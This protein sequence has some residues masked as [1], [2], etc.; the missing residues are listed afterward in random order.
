MIQRPFFFRA[1]TTFALF[2]FFV[3]LSALSLVAQDVRINEFLA[4]NQNGLTDEDGTYSDWIELFNASSA[5]VDLEGWSLTDDAIRLDKW[6]FPDVTVPSGGYL[7][8]FASGNDRTDPGNPLH[9]N[10]KLSGSGEYLALVDAGGRIVTEFSPFYPE[11]TVDQSWGYLN[12]DWVGFSEPTPGA[13]NGNAPVGS[14]PPPVF[15]HSHG[16]YSVPFQV[17]IET[18]V[19]GGIILYTLDGSIPVQGKAFSYITPINV[20]RTTVLRA[21]VYANG[22][23]ATDVNTQTYLFP[24]DIIFQSNTPEGYPDKWGPFTGISGQAPADYEMDP[25]MMADPVFAQRA[26]EALVHLPVISLVGDAGNF[27]SHEVDEE[28]GGIY[29]YTGPPLSNEENGLGDGWERPVSM[30]FF[31]VRGRE[32]LQI[33]CGIQLQGGHSRRPEKS[34]KHS[35]RMMFK[36]QYGPSR[37]NYPILGEE[38]KDSY[39]T[40]ILR[41]GFGNTWVHWTSDERVRAHNARDVWSKDTQRKM[42]HPS[43]R[44][45]FVHLFIN[46]IYW[47][48]YNPSERLDSD[49][50]ELYL[51]GDADDYDVIKDYSDVIDGDIG[52]WNRLHQQSASGMKTDEAYWK[53]QGKNPDGTRNPMY[54][55]LVDVDNLIDYMMINF[56]GGNTD[57]DHHNWVAMRN[58]VK[59]GNGF[60]FFCWDQEHVLKNVNENLLTEN[61]PNCPSSIFQRLRQNEN[62]KRRFADRVQMHCFDGGVLTP[63][64][65]ADR[66]MKRSLYLEGAIDAESARWGDYRR[67]VH[68][69]NTSGPFDLYTKEDYWLPVRETLLNNYFPQRTDKFLAQLKEAGL[70]P[71][72]SAPQLLLNGEPTGDTIAVPG[73]LLSLSASRGTVYYSLDG[74]EPAVW[75]GTSTWRGSPAPDA[76]IYSGAFA[77]NH[78]VHL[79]ARTLL[80]GQWSALKEAYLMVRSDFSDL[81]ITEIQYNPEGNELYA[82]SDFEFI[83]LKNTGSSTLNLNGVAFTSGID[84]TFQE[85]ISLAPGEFIVLASNEEAFYARYGFMPHGEFDGQLSNSGELLVLIGLQGD[86]LCSIAYD[87]EKGW[88]EEADG[89]GYSL[90][91]VEQNP[92]GNQNTPGQWRSSYQKNGSPKAD[93]LLN[94]VF[95]PETNLSSSRFH[96]GS[97]YPNPFQNLTT[98]DYQLFEDAHIT[99]TVHNLNGQMLITLVDRNLPAGHYQACWEGTTATGQRLPNGIYLY[100]MKMNGTRGSTVVSRKMALLR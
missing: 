25:E 63:Q 44:S 55:S 94:D 21:V 46:G 75:N 27:F 20:S 79:K 81:K 72:V 97:N 13:F 85:A 33:N 47:G 91:P 51:G 90:V 35:F 58:R 18:S 48:I 60:K 59:P 54:E 50:A 66:M 65:T 5:D 69:Y 41:A 10:F 36:S 17:S 82:G 14:Y 99:L 83:E 52:A 32:S 56:Y 2:V 43:S 40:L 77:L 45:I 3:S 1:G 84:Y 88:P 7:L 8:V 92:S 76:G 34:P 62:F 61:N 38:G 71:T 95:L 78:S 64:A 86:T 49:Y 67:D 4:L 19:A 23:P 37:L 93:D 80:N 24:D 16:F 31:D 87:D 73:D 53:I 68:P 100:R 96:L 98:I 6:T 70:F 15:S 42:G 74:S 30:E 89:S 26:K 11:Q 28:K 29:I 12:G 39:N 22:A 9:S 57:W